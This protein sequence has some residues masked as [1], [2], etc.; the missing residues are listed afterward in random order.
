MVPLLFATCTHPLVALLETT[1]AKKEISRLG[2]PHGEKF[3]VKLFADDSLLFLKVDTQNVRRGL[4][5]VQLFAQASGSQC[6]I[7]KSRLISLTKSDGFDY[8][9]WTREVLGKGKILRHLGAPLGYYT[10]PKQAFEW[11]QERIQKK[12]SKWR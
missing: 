1:A 7:G 9:G 3:L 10:S 12:M 8:V 5:L 2:L 11:V 4:A 6:N